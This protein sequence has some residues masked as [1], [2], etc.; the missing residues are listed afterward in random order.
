MSKVIQLMCVTVGMTRS[1]T[2]C[3]WQWAWHVGGCIIRKFI[4]ENSQAVEVT[5]KI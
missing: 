5:T 4:Q 3:S 1:H 2:T